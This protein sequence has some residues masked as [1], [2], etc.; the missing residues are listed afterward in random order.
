MIRTDHRSLKNLLGQVIQSPEQQYFL[1]RLLGFSFSI[2]YKK[3]KENAAANT[4]SWLPAVEA[5]IEAVQLKE[6]TSSLN[7]DWE[8]CM[9]VENKSDPWI[10][11]IVKR[12]G[13]GDFDTNFEVKGG[14]LYFRGKFCLGPTSDL[15]GRVLE[16][17]HNSRVGGHS[18]Y[19]RTLR[20]V[21]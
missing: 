18:G 7:S 21:R 13:R 9:Q 6:L 10:C 8:D 15:R 17:L 4:L 12:I 1:T 19:Q 20:R 14:I 2:V 5:E 11:E 16:E 3:G